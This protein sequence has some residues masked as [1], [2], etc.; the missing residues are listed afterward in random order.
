[1]KRNMF[2]FC[3]LR[4]EFYSVRAHFKNIFLKRVHIFPDTVE[5]YNTLLLFNIHILFRI[6]KCTSTS[7]LLIFTVWNKRTVEPHLM[8]VLRFSIFNIMFY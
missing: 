8:F 3:N 1:M 5:C 6:L 4:V 7:L 2:V